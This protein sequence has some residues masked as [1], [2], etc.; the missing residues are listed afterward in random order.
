MSP[1]NRPPNTATDSSRTGSRPGDWVGTEHK[2][3]PAERNLIPRRRVILSATPDAPSLARRALGAVIPP[4]ALHARYAQAFLVLSEIVS[5]AV[6]HG[7]G[8]SDT[9]GMLIDAEEVMLRVQVD[10]AGPVSGVHLVDPH[11]VATTGRGHG[12]QIVDG[13][14]DSWGTSEPDR[15]V[16]FEF[17]AQASGRPGP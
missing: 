7:S 1:P 13:F 3:I 11:F 5:N 16:W 4:P 14:A 9:I 2:G 12:L 17:R 6:E 8:P 15:S 10:Q